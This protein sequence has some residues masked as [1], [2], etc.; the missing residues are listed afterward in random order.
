MFFQLQVNVMLNP[1]LLLMLFFVLA[2]LR[3]GLLAKYQAAQTADQKFEFLRA[4]M[5]DPTHL[6]SLT[7]EAHYTELD[8]QES[9]SKWVEK[10]LYELEKL[11]NTPELKRFLQTKILDRQAGRNHP[12]DPTGEDPS[13]KLYWIYQET[14]DSTGKKKQ[15][16]TSIKAS[17]DI[18]QN[19]A[20]RAAIGDGLLGRAA[21]F[22][23]GG[24]GSGD[25]GDNG[26]G[27]NRNKGKGG[28]GGKKVRIC[29]CKRFV[30]QI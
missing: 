25:Q 15:V 23:K 19:K 22:G 29:S 3:P 10:P 1:Y 8:T 16:G 9:E 17:T 7:V 28:K 14:S 27:T 6:G 26:K 24:K 12:Q 30:P 11:Y 13:M 2:G 5:L 20:A 21:E 4:F 18:P